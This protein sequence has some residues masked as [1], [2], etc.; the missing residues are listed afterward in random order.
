[1][2]E[3]QPELSALEKM[4]ERR[5][6]LKVAALGVLAAGCNAAPGDTTSKLLGA[7]QRFNDWVQG[8]MF[9]RARL[10]P[11][12]AESELTPLS[13]FRVNGKDDDAP[14]FDKAAWRLEVKG[15]VKTPGVF[16]I[17]QIRSM[18]KK[19]Q[20]TKHIC[21][22]GWSINPKWGGTVLAGL[23]AAV[24]ADPDAKYLYAE[25]ADGYYVPYDMP[26][27]LHPQTLLCYEAYNAPLSLDHG[28]PLRIVMPTKL[29]Y[30]SAK[31]L[32]KLTVTNEKPG[33]YWEDQGYDWYAGI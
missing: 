27:A 4:L 9:S 12:F 32:T 24:G 15:L 33:G 13:G 18:P 28:A 31:W 21:V 25:C 17:E 10:V 20:N 29:G 5:T 19:V 11:E 14:K 16:T 22:E 6:F 26:S 2:N 30:K 1:M 7:S 3:E 23:L 8:A